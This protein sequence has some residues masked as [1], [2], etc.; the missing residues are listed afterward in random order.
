MNTFRNW[1]IRLLGGTPRELELRRRA[2]L[3]DYVSAYVTYIELCAPEAHRE[4]NWD[5][6]LMH[7]NNIDNDIK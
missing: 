6:L 5:D 1:L 7:I 4:A 2:A 3:M